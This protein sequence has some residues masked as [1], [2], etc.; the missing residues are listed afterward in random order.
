MIESRE[1][2]YGYEDFFHEKIF[3]TLVSDIGGYDS[4]RNY[5]FLLLSTDGADPFDA[6]KY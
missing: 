2:T 5:V 4:I 6:T 1:N 3:K